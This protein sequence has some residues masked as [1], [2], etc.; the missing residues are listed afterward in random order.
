MYTILYQVSVALRTRPPPSPPS[1]PLPAPFPLRTHSARAALAC[2]GVFATYS[3]ITNV[4]GYVFLADP[5]DGCGRMKRPKRIGRGS[6]FVFLARLTTNS[7][8][9]AMEQNYNAWNAGAA[10]IINM[11]PDGDSNYIWILQ[12]TEADKTL[13][14]SF[15]SAGSIP[16]VAVSGQSGRKLETLVRQGNGHIKISAQG[17]MQEEEFLVIDLAITIVYVPCS[18]SVA[19]IIVTMSLSSEAANAKQLICRGGWC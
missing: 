2:A 19:I 1:L 15:Q 7:T 13:P 9:T 14:A 5:M 4:A 17:E 12:G 18:A 8:C 6:R 16:Q 11:A 3:P 10:G